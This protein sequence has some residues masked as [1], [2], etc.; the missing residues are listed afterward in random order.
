MLENK[1][2]NDVI[3]LAQFSKRNMIDSILAK[4]NTLFEHKNYVVSNF[5]I[6]NAKKYLIEKIDLEII[7]NHWH[8]EKK[9]ESGYLRRLIVQQNIDIK[10]NL[11]PDEKITKSDAK[12]YYNI[13]LEELSNLFILDDPDLP[14]I[15]INK[16]SIIN[17][18]KNY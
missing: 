14:K 4:I 15:I 10:S 11:I 7:I 16:T 6:D 17:Q 8:K 2:E 13:I 18:L 5:N 9:I 12:N 3:K 1:Y